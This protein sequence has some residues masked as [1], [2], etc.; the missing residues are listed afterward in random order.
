MVWVIVAARYIWP[1]L[2]ERSRADALQPILLLHGFRFIGLAFLVPG[3][4]S[5]ELPAAFAEPAGYGDLVAAVLALVALAALRTPF[6]IA[7]AWVFYL[8]VAAC[9]G[10][11][12]A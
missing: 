11:A 8:W 12:A 10:A 2:R 6:G 4:V 3:V 5:P 1:A 7:L 9:S